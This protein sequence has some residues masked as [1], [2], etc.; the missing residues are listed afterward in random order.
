MKP[1]DKAIHGMVS[2]SP[3]R[4]ASEP[5]G[6]LERILIRRLSPLWSGEGSMTWRR[7]TEATWHFGG[8]VGTAR[9][10]GHAK[11]LEKPSSSHRENRWSKVARITGETGKASEGETVAARPVVAGKRGNA[12]GAKGP[13]C[14]ERL[15]QEGR[16]G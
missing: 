8:V 7:L 16:P 11:Q 1:T 13:C 6:G 10:Q 4:N 3:G 2:E 12:R 14:T 15:I 5:R 9:W